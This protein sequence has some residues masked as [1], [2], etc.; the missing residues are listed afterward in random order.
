MLV[1]LLNSAFVLREILDAGRDAR[2]V[3]VSHAM[4]EK[5]E[6]DDPQHPSIRAVEENSPTTSLEGLVDCKGC[7]ARPH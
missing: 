3:A 7:A 5:A 4:A 6:E 1:A 2:I